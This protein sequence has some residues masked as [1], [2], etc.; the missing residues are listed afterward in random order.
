M[1]VIEHQLYNELFKNVR[2]WAMPAIEERI[3]REGYQVILGLSPSHEFSPKQRYEYGSYYW[4]NRL[5]E[6]F[7]RL[8]DIRNMIGRSL[9]RKKNEEKSVLLQEWIVYNYEHYAIVYQSILEIALLLTN[10]IFDMGTPYEKCSY[11]TV[12]NN[13]RLA[14]T[15]V[16][17]ILKELSNITHKHREGKNFLVHRGERIKLPIESRT[18]AEVDVINMA[19]KLGLET[20]EDVKEALKLFLEIHTKRD[21]LVIMDKEYK[22]IELQVEKLF[23]KLLPYYRRMRSFYS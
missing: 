4:C 14:G 18:F 16:R 20:K 15:G 6:A 12:Y 9:Y 22:Q 5:W 8:R 17:N 7:D 3:R 19:I 2:V 23:D 13:T 11:S 10:D 21:L 1:A